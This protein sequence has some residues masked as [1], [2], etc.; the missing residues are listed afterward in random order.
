MFGLFKF[1]KKQCNKLSCRNVAISTNFEC[2]FR[3]EERVW[4]VKFDVLVWFAEIV[5]LCV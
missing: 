4:K 5:F 2:F 1:G 3:G